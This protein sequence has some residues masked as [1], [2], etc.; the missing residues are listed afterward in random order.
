[1]LRLYDERTSVVAFHFLAKTTTMNAMSNPLLQPDGR[2][3]RPSMVD[4]EGRNHFGDS[5]QVGEDRPSGD[6]L[7]PPVD[8]AEP[9]QPQYQGYVPHRGGLIAALG[10][11]GFALSWLLLL[12][13]SSYAYLGLAA[14]LVGI[15]LSLG[16]TVMAFHDLKGFAVGAIDERGHEKTLLGFRF[17]LAG[18][19]VGG[20]AFI[21]VVWLIVKGYFELG[22]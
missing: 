2:F 22:L 15:T 8:D 20:G 16:T 10:V 11:T 3:R 21:A 7:A 9:Y 18:L 4:D 14:S 19:F 5:E 6:I 13:Y 17:A 1:M 12:A